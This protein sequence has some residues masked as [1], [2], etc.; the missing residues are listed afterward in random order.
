[1]RSIEPIAVSTGSLGVVKR[2][3]SVLDEVNRIQVFRA[4]SAEV[5]AGGD[6]A[7]KSGS[8]VIASCLQRAIA[9]KVDA[10]RFLY[11]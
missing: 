9:Y 3:I 1:V 4:K 10:R 5:F 11:Q 8:T 7:G 2:C 6:S